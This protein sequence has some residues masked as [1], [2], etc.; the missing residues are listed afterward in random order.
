MSNTQ[1]QTPDLIRSQLRMNI[2]QPVVSR[3]TAAQLELHLSRQQ[4]EFVMHHQN[5]LGCDLEESRQR[6]D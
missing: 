4:I 5:L 1:L 6:R 2:F 3:W